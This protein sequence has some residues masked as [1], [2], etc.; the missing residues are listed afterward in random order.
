MKNIAPLILLILAAW[1]Y[2]AGAQEACSRIKTIQEKKL[3]DKIIISYHLY[4]CMDGTILQ[5]LSHPTC[6]PLAARLKEY[7]CRLVGKGIPE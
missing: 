5:G 1:F 4:N 2:Q 6:A 7:I 3:V